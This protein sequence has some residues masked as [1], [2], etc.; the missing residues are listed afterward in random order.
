MLQTITGGVTVL[1]RVRWLRKT[2]A[3]D[4]KPHQ[5]GGDASGLRDEFGGEETSPTPSSGRVMLGKKRKM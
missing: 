4:K 5:G 3:F 2:G 1:I